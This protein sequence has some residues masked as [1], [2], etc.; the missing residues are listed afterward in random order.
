VANIGGFL[1]QLAQ[2]YLANERQKYTGVSDEQAS[3]NKL[4]VQQAQTAAEFQRP[5]AEAELRSLQVRPEML[6]AEAERKAR[7]DAE[8]V[9]HRKAI[10]ALMGRKETREETAA[11]GKIA[12]TGA[13]TKELGAPPAP[14]APRV[15]L[16]DT[17]DEAGNPVRKAVEVS[18][19]EVFPGALTTIEKTRRDQAAHVI[20]QGAAFIRELKQPKTAELFGPRAG[21]VTQAKLSKPGGFVL[22]AAPPEATHARSA[23]ASLSAFLPIMHG[24]RGGENMIQHFEQVLGDFTSPPENVAAATTAIMEAAKRIREKG[25]QADLTDLV[26]QTIT[27][28]T[29]AEAAASEKAPHAITGKRKYTVVGV[30]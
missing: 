17:V 26:P 15:Q 29:G 16:I 30:E 12:L 23:L 10:E 1:Q 21:L 2:N 8:L 28:M 3:L 27:S 19:G 18:A 24:M 14:K 20:E 22:G 4:G 7:A 11:P 25:D 6:Q 5:K 13:R 9:L